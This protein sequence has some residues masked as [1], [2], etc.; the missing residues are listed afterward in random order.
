M[1]LPPDIV[2]GEVVALVGNPRPASR[3]TAAARA[4]ASV[5]SGAAAGEPRV[6]EVSDLTPDR[7]AGRAALLEA[8]RAVRSAGVLVVATPVFKAGPT[9]ALKSFLD[10]LEPTALEAT[11]AVPVVVAASAAHG[12]LA[13]LQL[14]IVLQAVGALL[15]V[16][17]V[18]LEEHRLDELPLQAAEWQRRFGTAVEA[19]AR[20]LH[21]VEVV[22][23]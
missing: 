1:S 3:T 22:L 2:R 18:V 20:A 8:Q 7:A 19:V 6:V 21:P 14:R 23:P 17:S 16:P 12:A 9:G 15:P 10:G 13:D 4:V 11:V 5:L